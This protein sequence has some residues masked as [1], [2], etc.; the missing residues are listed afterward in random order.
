MI[1]QL[2]H[3]PSSLWTLPR[4]FLHTDWT[5]PL[6]LSGRQ[7]PVVLL[8][9]EMVMVHVH[10]TWCC[11]VRRK[12]PV[13][14]R[15]SEWMKDRQYFQ[16]DTR[17]KI[18]PTLI[19]VVSSSA[20]TAWRPVDLLSGRGRDHWKEFTSYQ[21]PRRLAYCSKSPPG[22]TTTKPSNQALQASLPK[23]LKTGAA[24]SAVWWFSMPA[25]GQHVLLLTQH[26]SR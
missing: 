12:G 4:S 18:T 20:T 26:E 16:S 5:H 2:W 21:L 14:A 7:Q 10:L 1:L 17:P 15:A 19:A 23:A 24:A 11:S 25:G 8:S 22:R 3:L 9:C 13:P 6:L